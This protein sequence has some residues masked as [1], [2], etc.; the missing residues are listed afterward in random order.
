[1]KKCD[2]IIPVYNA[3]DY[4]KICVQ[5]IIRNTDLN[6]HQLIIINDCSTDVNVATYLEK[7]RK[8]YNTLN[9]IVK[10]NNENLGFVK[11][12]NRGMK[13]S[14]N[15]VLLLNSDTEVSSNWLK[16]IIECAYSKRDIA[17]VTAL[18]NNATLASVPN[19]LQPNDIPDNM[20]FDTYANLVEECS[21]KQYPQIPT[22]HGF[23]MFIKR[24]V[25]NIVGL[26]N[27]NAFGKGYGEE[28]DFS[29][30]C[31][32]YGYR[33]VL[34][35]NVLVLHKESKSFTKNKEELIKQNLKKL[36]DMHPS[37]V[38]KIENWCERYPIDYI[39]KNI[40]YSSKI[41]NRKN[42]L[43]IIHDWT[44]IENN[45]GGTTIH[46]LDLIK[47]LRNDY[48]IHVLAPEKGLFKLFSYF[49]DDESIL[50]LNGVYASGR[51]SF[52]NDEY[53]NLL[54]EI[55]KG[56]NIAAIHVHH[57]IGHYFDLIDVAKRNN[58]KT[59][60]TLHDFYSLCPSINM[61]YNMEKY[62]LDL[63][64]KD[65]SNCLYNKMKIKENIVSHWQSEWKYF[66]TQFDYIITPSGSTK[67]II[68]KELNIPNIKVIEHGIDIE[69]HYKEKKSEV[70]NVAFIGVMAIHKGAREIIEL[71]S[72]NKDKEIK[73]H[74]FGDSEFNELKRNRNNYIYHGRY[75]R[76][77]LPHLMKEN[78]IDIVCN[79]SIWPETYSYTL[80][81]TIA[82]GV[83]VLCYNIG[84]VCERINTNGFGWV[85]SRNA[86][87]D[88]IRKKLIS[89][90]D[91]NGEYETILN[92]IR[93]YKVKT[94]DEM[95]ESYKLLY[96]ESIFNELE[97]QYL[98]DLIMS[99]SKLKIA[100]SSSELDRIL[101]SRKWK[102]VSKIKVPEVIRK[103]G[104]K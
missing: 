38:K 33:N 90:A 6:F 37:Y 91:N 87:V 59:F 85:I 39:G 10:E 40:F 81:E 77:D 47:G 18:S 83:P 34:C 96:D 75:K 21:Y 64:E 78:N 42:I 92:N 52:Y 30:R 61:L 68:E 95:C 53:Y 63:K 66:L 76:N 100:G 13:E 56:L 11:T 58:I 28:N 70:L 4:L 36:E 67:E 17:T 7:L 43:F 41:K 26:F 16:N 49:K 1:M 65:C 50:E 46:C 101:N 14:E 89:I 73:Y 44:D 84:A 32:D 12:V 60:I 98:R 99:D 97:Y 82:S 79:L 62:C 71:I 31:M 9:I 2:I 48:N 74:L 88:D 94:I 3:L 35:D 25:I 69:R 15:D 8:D 24:E 80:T 23:C 57:M 72:S 54:D 45:L 102:L 19:G 86:T 22:A 27:A 29:F 55:V 51:I 104:Q 5:S 20:S 93:H 103:I